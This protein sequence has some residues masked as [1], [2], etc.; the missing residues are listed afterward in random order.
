MNQ[1]TQ[2]AAMA[3]AWRTTATAKPCLQLGLGDG[4]LTNM[5]VADPNEDMCCFGD[6]LFSMDLHHEDSARAHA[7]RRKKRLAHAHAH[8]QQQEQCHVHLSNMT[9]GTR[10]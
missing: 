2:H 7:R 6:S 5:G 1:E 8:Q 3:A 10:G 9:L 4:I